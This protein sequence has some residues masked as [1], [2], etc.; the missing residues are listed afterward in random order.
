MRG[1]LQHALANL[2]LS[3]LTRYASDLQRLTEVLQRVSLELIAATAGRT[4]GK[5]RRIR[6]PEPTASNAMCGL[7]PE[8][9]AGKQFHTQELDSR[10]YPVRLSSQ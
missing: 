5:R 8:R 4:E 9:G 2:T 6:D 1:A 10:S 3:S 7:P